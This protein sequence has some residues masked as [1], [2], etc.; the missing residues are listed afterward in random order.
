M[1]FDLTIRSQKD[2][3]AYAKLLK[4]FGFHDVNITD[5]DRGQDALA[6]AVALRELLPDADIVL[7]V[8]VK[9]HVQ[10]TP[11][12][13]QSS[14]RKLFERARKEKIKK[15][16]LVSG[17]PRE[18]FNALDALQLL[19]SSGASFDEVSCVYNPFFDPARLREEQERLER[20]LSYPFVNGIC[21]Q[22]GVDT[23]KLEK[24]IKAVRAVR[25]DARV[26][27]SL[28]M[29]DPATRK[30][31]SEDP[32]YGV[33]LP[34]SFLQNDEAAAE[35]TKGVLELFRKE[36]VTPVVYMASPNAKGFEQLMELEQ[37]L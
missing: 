15:L 12:A 17:Y 29:P 28:A 37:S 16:L 7:H 11:D 24:G 10:A 26:L 6:D 9:H 13:T 32:L 21:M 33:F 36:N 8:S 5:T 35:A 20:K 2:L 27:C 23:H 31:L 19:Q 3:E 30:R 1:R 4:E 34:Q 18:R 14:L 22:M 25:E